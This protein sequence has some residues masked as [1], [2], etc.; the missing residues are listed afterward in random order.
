MNLTA[1]VALFI[2]ISHATFATS[3]DTLARYSG[4]LSDLSLALLAAWIFNLLIV[5]LPRRRDRAQLYSGI[6]WMIGLMAQ[7]GLSMMEHLSHAAKESINLDPQVEGIIIAADRGATDRIC[8]AIGPSTPY[9]PIR[10]T[11]GC[12]ELISNPV[13]MLVS[14]TAGFNPGYRLSM[15]RSVP[16]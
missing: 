10:G 13:Q 7:S 5:E 6:A 16:R 9:A 4:V 14:I 1:V 8:A 12:W 15:S 11:A 3:S 2:V